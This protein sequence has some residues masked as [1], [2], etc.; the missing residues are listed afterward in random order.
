MYK[1]EIDYTKQF[2]IIDM[3]DIIGDRYLDMGLIGYRMEKTFGDYA[4][5]G[6]QWIAHALRKDKLEKPLPPILRSCSNYSYATLAH[7]V[8]IVEEDLTE[9]IISAGYGNE[10][11]GGRMGTFSL[12]KD[13]YERRP[14]LRRCK[15]LR[16]PSITKL[17]KAVE[18]VAEGEDIRLFLDLCSNFVRNDDTLRDRTVGVPA[19]FEASAID[20]I[21]I[22]DKA[23]IDCNYE[24]DT[25]NRL[26]MR[27]SIRDYEYHQKEV[28]LLKELLCVMREEPLRGSDT[29]LIDPKGLPQLGSNGR[30]FHGVDIWGNIKE[31]VLYLN[32][33]CVKSKLGRHAYLYDPQVKKDLKAARGW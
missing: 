9:W 20:F 3:R 15:R 1:L 31:D 30:K 33:M 21:P 13:M 23:W 16:V 32:T 10:Y 29:Y 7:I 12:T 6:W 14:I 25:Q 2:P 24:Y 19:P 8:K 5:Y 27:G 4:Y 22:L 17:V 26:K 28:E 11:C 18:K